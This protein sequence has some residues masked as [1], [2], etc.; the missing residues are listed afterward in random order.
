RRRHRC[1]AA[2]GEKRA[3]KG[4]LVRMQETAE[5]A[6]GTPRVESRPRYGTVIAVQ[7]PAQPATARRGY[8]PCSHTWRPEQP[9]PIPASTDRCARSAR[10]YTARA[11]HAISATA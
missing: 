8:P 7:V 3:A 4:G 6:R 2:D 1:A 9:A 5:A 11:R 10:G